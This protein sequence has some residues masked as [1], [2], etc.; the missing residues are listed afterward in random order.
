MKITIGKIS[1]MILGEPCRGT[2]K[3]LGH[4]IITD[5]CITQA[6]ILTYTLPCGEKLTSRSQTFLLS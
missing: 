5:V 1:Q 6:V 4:C 2:L 3:S